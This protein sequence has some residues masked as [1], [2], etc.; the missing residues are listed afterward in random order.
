MLR[1]RGAHATELI[2]CGYRFSVPCRHRKMVNSL[3]ISDE[4][5]GMLECQFWQ[6]GLQMMTFVRLAPISIFLA[7]CVLLSNAGAAQAVSFDLGSG[8][9]PRTFSSAS[10]GTTSLVDSTGGIIVG[11]VDIAGPATVSH[12]VGHLSIVARTVT[13]ASGSSLTFEGILDITASESVYVAGTLALAGSN[14]ILSITSPSIG[15]GLNGFIGNTAIIIPSG[16]ITLVIPEPEKYVLLMAGL[17]LI[18]TTAQRKT[19]QRLQE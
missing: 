2:E 14:S 7:V 3:D 5:L 11:S 13:I 8:P 15:S 6:L 17:T 9:F 16:P 12:A 19:R 1:D 18:L 10:D 4:Y